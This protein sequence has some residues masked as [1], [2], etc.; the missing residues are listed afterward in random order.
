MSALL[1]LRCPSCGEMQEIAADNTPCKKCST[2]LSAV[3]MGVLQLYR[4]GSPIG[5]AVGYGIYLNTLPYG[6]VGN[7]ET[8][9]IA[10]P[11]GTYNLHCTCGMTRKCEDFSFTLSPS[12]PCIYAK[13]SIKMGFWTNKINI[14]PARAEEMPPL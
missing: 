8:V 13:A 14:T 2:P 4:M 10:L 6:H 9:R 5:V 7:T 1:R 11:Y 3:N 12:V